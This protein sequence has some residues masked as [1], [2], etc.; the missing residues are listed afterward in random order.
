MINQLII[1]KQQIQKDQQTLTQ[2]QVQPQKPIHHQK[3][4]QIHPWFSF[5]RPPIHPTNSTLHPLNSSNRA[6]SSQPS[7]N[8]YSS[9]FSS[10]SLLHSI[11]RTQDHQQNLLYALD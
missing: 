11:I 2:D 7:L 5:L 6:Y 9:R 3:T 1:Q 10:T 4:P 8:Q